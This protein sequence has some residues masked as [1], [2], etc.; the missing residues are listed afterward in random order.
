M[1]KTKKVDEVTESSD[2]LYYKEKVKNKTN[3]PL[4]VY[5]AYGELVTIAPKSFAM[6]DRGRRLAPERAPTQEETSGS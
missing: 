6:V 5:N 3:R 1:K 4:L 2:I